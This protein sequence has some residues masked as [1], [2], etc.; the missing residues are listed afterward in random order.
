[1]DK[2]T[3]LLAN[4]Y[5]DEFSDN[6]SDRI[7]YK[8][9]IA[10]DFAWVKAKTRYY[11]MFNNTNT[12]SGKADRINRNYDLY[13]GIIDES[14]F[15]PIVNTLNIEDF[16]NPVKMEHIDIISLPIREI[17]GSEIK[18]PFEPIA[19]AVNPEAV[20][21]KEKER[22]EMLKQYIYSELMWPI[23]EQLTKKY[24]NKDTDEKQQKMYQEE[25][26]S[27][28]PEDI[29]KFMATEFRLPE[30]SLAQDLIDYLTREHKL[31]F[32]FNKGWEKAVISGEEVYYVG[33]KNGKEYIEVV[34]NRY[35]NY[36]KSAHNYFIHDAEWCTYEKYM[37]IS[38]LYDEFSEEIEEDK[39]LRKRLELLT[40]FRNRQKYEQGILIDYDLD[41]NAVMSSNRRVRVLHVVFKSLKK[42]K[43][44]KTMDI[45]TGEESEILVDESYKF[46][47][48]IDIE[49]RVAWIP[50]YW[51]STLIDEDIYLRM[52]P[53]PNQYRNLNDPFKIKS[54]Y[55]G[56][57]YGVH[58]GVPISLLDR[59]YSFQFMYDVIWFR[60]METLATDRGNV[61]LAV[62]KQIPSGW[63]PKQWLQYLFT[64]KV[65][66]IDSSQDVVQTGSDPQYWKS[67]N[68]SNNADIQKY[69]QLLD[70]CEQRCLRAIGSNEN[71]IGTVTPYESVTN[72]QQKIVQSSNI[73]EPDFYLHNILKEE[74]LTGLLEQAKIS[75]RENP[76]N[77]SY[78]TSDL[79]I[80]S[81]TVD[82]V[83]LESA[84]FAVYASNSTKDH[85]IV[86]TLRNQI[87]RIVQASQGDFRFLTEVVTANNPQKLK[88]MADKIAQD[89]DEMMRQQ[90]EAQQQQLKAQQEMQQQQMQHDKEERQLDR[91]YRLKEAMIKAMG[92][93]NIQDTDANQVPDVLELQKFNAD[94]ALKNTEVGLK[95]KELSLR[96]KELNENNISEERDR[97]VQREKIKADLEKERIKA[98]NKPGQKKQ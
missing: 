13:N 79:N 78:I 54:P 39:D 67:I 85:S 17:I 49:E 87:D 24:P 37:L 63:S 50:E 40:P 81:L 12:W 62:L 53:L 36:D 32:L 29:D 22:I 80:K 7:S 34:D 64:S 92:F 61:L 19:I 98:R 47:P 10:N 60:L 55:M 96:E 93:A 77:I 89:K 33:Q 58:N 26:N 1:M 52:R 71:R 65:G 23:E 57:A 97:E 9:K 18:R 2:A 83:L 82:P 70:Y 90:S 69:L 84:E 76:R 15:D 3:R 66:F 5:N 45:N 56:V 35:F 31:E 4:T 28:K 41:E 51:E 75:F 86:Q 27:M 48:M 20:T 88:E 42:I 72:N 95:S 8:K 68:L 91:E 43:F 11:D 14:I 73:T 74:V 21:Q 38:D 25:L 94:L 46:N 30:E 59:G 16:D 44:I 6:L